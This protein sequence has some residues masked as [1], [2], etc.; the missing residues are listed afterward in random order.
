MVSHEWK[1]PQACEAVYR[2][3]SST[4]DSTLV[5]LW[6]QNIFW[7]GMIFCHTTVA[8]KKILQMSQQVSFGHG[9]S[10]VIP[11]WMSRSYLAVIASALAAIAQNPSQ[12]TKGFDEHF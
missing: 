4:A 5:W 8:G 11:L 3:Y 1:V 12:K 2:L 9:W 10:L 7:I 6:L